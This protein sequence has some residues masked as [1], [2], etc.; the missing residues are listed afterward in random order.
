MSTA[1]PSSA[2][3]TQPGPDAA[4]QPATAHPWLRRLTTAGLLV[5]GGL[6]WW[7]ISTHHFTVDDTAEPPAAEPATAAGSTPP[8]APLPGQHFVTLSPAAAEAAG[9]SL[10]TADR[11]VLGD[12]VTVP[13]RLDYDAR[14]RVDYASP[15]DGIVTAVE[16]QARDA[17]AAG[18]VLAEISSPAV[19]MARDEVRRRLDDR[20]IAARAL[21]WATTI[22]TNV[23]AVLNRLAKGPAPEAIQEE[24]ATKPLGGY[25]EKLLGGYSRMVLAQRIDTG[26]R[27][28][29]EGGILSGR[30]VDERRSNYEVAQSNFRAACEEARFQ[31]D[32]DRAKAKADYDQSDR[33]LRIARDHLHTLTGSRLPSPPTTESDADGPPADAADASL[34]GLFLR[35]PFAG[36]VEDIFIAEGERVEAGDDLFVVADTRKL[37]VRAQ[38]HERQWTVVEIAAGDLVEV[39]VPGTEAHHTVARVKH[40]GATVE[41]DSRSVPL[42]A[43]LDN[44]DAHY[45]PGGFVWVT[46]PLGRPQ[47]EVAIPN[48]AVQHY[49]GQAFVFVP[50]G[51]HRYRRQD[52]TTGLE[53]EGFTAILAGLEDGQQ[54]VD[55]GSFTLKSE[56]LLDAE[57]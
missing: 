42:V 31:T 45:K 39:T 30:I 43:E 56:L 36:I 28:L 21:E 33:Q 37:W 11:R 14:H 47:A 25:R 13:G 48:S 29:G 50:A 12:R 17:I 6:A 27:Q 20:A 34:S 2:V 4:G 46:L 26:T 40:I 55:R 16:V 7:W 8:P 5:T 41:A 3:P 22:A 1:T 19:G 35:A 10:V 32:Q 52:V 54:V 57:E 24:F 38:I 18:A 51:G 49:G 23:E 9:I 53:K 44:D 15:V